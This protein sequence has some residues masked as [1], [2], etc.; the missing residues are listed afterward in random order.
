MTRLARVMRYFIAPPDKILMRI[1]RTS[2][3][4]TT[5]SDG[6]I[7][8]DENGNLSL[9]LNNKEAQEAFLANVKVISG[10]LIKR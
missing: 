1:T 10:G 2:A 8:V 7:I 3:H 6:K 9:N 5:A 4:G